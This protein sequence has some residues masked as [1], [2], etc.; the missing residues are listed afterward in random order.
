MPVN[1]VFYSNGVLMAHSGVVTDEDLLES[2]VEL[3]SHE[4]PEGLQFQLVDLT[5]VRDFQA[6]HKTMRY[7]G[8]KDREFSQTHGRQLIVVIA[9]THGRANTIVWEVWAQD[10]STNDPALLTKIVD[11]RD[12]AIQ[13]L[14]D[15]GIEIH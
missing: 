11:R 1:L 12:E 10:T 2:D 14:K 3:Y 15:N 5:D 4:Y 13:W 6:S 7:L 9:P 8:E